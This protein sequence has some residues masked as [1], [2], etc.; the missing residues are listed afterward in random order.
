MCGGRHFVAAIILE[1]ALYP[2]IPCHPTGHAGPHLA[3]GRISQALFVSAG[4]SCRFFAMGVSA[5]F[6]QPSGLRPCSLVGRSIRVGLVPFSAAG[7]PVR[8]VD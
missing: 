5:P 6:R 8:L 2:V 1:S 3:V 4:L 7:R